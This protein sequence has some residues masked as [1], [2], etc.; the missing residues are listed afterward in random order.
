M[1]E[2]RACVACHI[3]AVGAGEPTLLAK[4][5]MD[6]LSDENLIPEQWLVVLR[7]EGVEPISLT[8]PIHLRWGIGKAEVVLRTYVDVAVRVLAWAGQEVATPLRFYVIEG[9]GDAITVSW[10]SMRD[11]KITADLEALVGAQRALGLTL[12]CPSPQA[13][14]PVQDMDGRNVSISERDVE[15]SERDR[16]IEEAKSV[17]EPLDA[18][19]VDPES[20]PK[21]VLFIGRHSLE[22][23]RAELM[24]SGVFQPELERGGESTL[25]PMEIRLQEGFTPPVAKGGRRYAPRV[26]TALE[27]EIARQLRLGVIEECDDPP[28]QEVVMVRKD[29]AASGFRFTL[30]ARG[31]NA[32]MVTEPCN[33]PPIPEV[34]RGLAGCS[35]LAR[36]DLASAYWQFPVRE[37]SRPL[38]AFRVGHRV[39]RYCVVWMGGAGASHFVQKGLHGLLQ[40]Y[41]GNGIWVYI[42]DIVLAAET[43]EEFVALLRHTVAKLREANLVCKLSKCVIGC[44]SLRLL[45]HIVD[46]RAVR[47]AD[48]RREEV[49]RLPFPENPKQLRAALGQANFQRTF[50]PNYAL[51]TKP[52]SS[53]VNGTTAQMRT[54]EARAAWTALMAAVA[55]QLSLAHL[56]Y[57]E[58]IRVRV[59]SSI[60]GVGGALFN[61][62]KRADG[63][64]WE[65]L[66]A[67][68]SHAYTEAE[69]NWATIEQEAFAMVFACRYWLPLLSGVRFVLDGDHKNLQYIHGGTSPK[70]IR[71]GLFMQSLDCFYNHI[72]GIDNFFPDRLSRQDFA[73][74]QSV[75]LAIEDFPTPDSEVG[76]TQ[77]GKST[78]KKLSR[79]FTR[80]KK[81]QQ[82][83]SGTAAGGAEQDPAPPSETGDGQPPA[84]PTEEADDAVQQERIAWIREVHNNGEGHHGIH[85][86]VWM[87]QAAGHHWP[88]MGRDVAEFIETCISC[89]KNRPQSSLPSAPRGTM[90]QYTLFAEVAIDFIG[91]LPT[92][93]LGNSFI[94]GV[95]CL[96]SSKLEAFAVEA[97]SAVCA[98]H[99]LV[100][101][102]ARYSAPWSIRSD[103]GTHFVNEIIE[104]L[105]RVF[106]ITRVLTP[107]YRPQANSAEERNGGEA[108]RH[109]R[110]LTEE[111]DA[112]ELWSVVLAL[113]N[114]IVDHTYKWWLG[115]RPIDLVYVVPQS[116]DR[117]MF[118]PFRPVNETVPVSTEFV[119]Q[120]RR[121]YER[122]LDATS[123]R[124]LAEQ[125]KLERVRAGDKTRPV[126]AGDLVL[127]RY[128]VRPPSKLHERVAGPFQVVQRKGNLIFAKDLTSERVLERDAEMVIPFLQ[129]YPMSKEELVKVAARD[130]NEV[131][132]TAISNHRGSVK[133]RAAMEFQVQWDDGEVSWEPWS[134][135]KKLEALDQYIKDHPQLKAL[136]GRKTVGGV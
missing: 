13:D 6:S 115:C 74:D 23:L 107:P 135:V 68:C 16:L 51:I 9:D 33:P 81:L 102:S 89:Q 29:D 92:D 45:G 119:T 4:A 73:R 26:Q 27:E 44:F 59:D 43:A 90:R 91:P 52:L 116:G 96:F 88:K 128:P 56:D 21:D 28:A 17:K 19:F 104:E 31:V 70:V 121:T 108:I 98:A 48:D 14:P 35:Y 54:P 65:R 22:Y 66:V 1:E 32:G 37:E 5:N 58:Q 46:G 106:K 101:I 103:R 53:L 57:K 132:V 83:A 49:A 110:A 117:G 124:I 87:L 3:G 95:T 97:A 130:L 85:R 76:A 80:G 36:L 39:Y 123:T 82:N 71:W 75:V 134:V 61:V 55:G 47:I 86:T 2:P 109:L 113:A 111:P 112:R 131:G 63:E 38:S 20:V 34:L 79:A 50:I 24:A 40:K 93:Q 30:D 25:P 11:L 100:S 118:D 10:K 84:K 67:V 133:K 99:C 129:P 62:G 42:D 127:I 78:T 94:L 18:D 8:D 122:M 69:R 41:I 114:R 136:A 60:V 7:G 72:A 126:V 64:P 120:L 105:C 15:E 77:P 125:R 12:T